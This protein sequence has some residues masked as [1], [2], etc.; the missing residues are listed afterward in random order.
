[1]T[2]AALYEQFMKLSDKNTY[3][4][5]KGAA[6]NVI[7]AMITRNSSNVDEATAQWNELTNWFEQ[8]IQKRY[9]LGPDVH[10]PSFTIINGDR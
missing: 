3:G 9:A 10:T 8:N 5:I 1:M 2:Q 7:L 6:A 4:T